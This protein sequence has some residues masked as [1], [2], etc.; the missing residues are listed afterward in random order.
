M[1]F[2]VGCGEQTESALKVVVNNKT[3][4]ETSSQA[5]T[6]AYG[7][8]ID[9]DAV[10]VMSDSTEKA[11]DTSL[12]QVTGDSHIIGTKPNAGTYELVFK[13]GDFEI[14]VSVVVT[15]LELIVPTAVNSTF[16]YN[17]EAQSL[18][19]SGFDAT[20]MQVTG[21]SYTD[22]D[23]YTAVISL[24]DKVNYTWSDGTTT[25]KSIAWTIAKA[26]VNV[27]TLA[28][29]V[30]YTYNGELQNVQLVGFETNLMHKV[31]GVSGIDADDYT[32]V[33]S[34]KDTDNYTWAD[35]TTANKNISWSIEKAR[36]NV[37]T[38]AQ[39]VEYT[40]NGELQEVEFTGYNSSIMNKVSGITG[41][42]ADDYTAVISLKDKT[43]YS[44]S[45]GT[46]TD[47]NISWSIEKAQVSVPTVA[48]NAT[49]T[50]N[51]ELQEV[52]FTGYNSSIMNK[53][54]GIT[55][56]DADDYTA[57]ISLKDTDNYTWTDGTT[58]NKNITWTINKKAVEVKLNRVLS[59]AYDGLNINNPRYSVTDDV[60]NSYKLY[61]LAGDEPVEVELL[62]IV[63]VGN[64]QLVVSTSD[65]SGN[66]E[67]INETFDF[68]IYYDI[69]LFTVELENSSFA[70]TGNELKPAVKV[71]MGVDGEENPIYL[72]DTY[73]EVIYRNNVMYYDDAYVL[74]QAKGA[75]VGEIIKSF[76]IFAE[77]VYDTISVNDKTIDANENKYDLT[78][79]LSQ[80]P[81][82]DL[83]VELILKDGYK[84]YTCDLIYYCYDEN[85]RC[86]VS[87]TD[88]TYEQ[89]LDGFTVPSDTRKL[90]FKF[91]NH[92]AELQMYSSGSCLYVYIEVVNTPEFIPNYNY[93]SDINVQSVR[94]DNERNTVMKE[95]LFT[96]DSL[97]S[98]IETAINDS[99]YN[100]SWN[101]NELGYTVSSVS[102]DNGYIVFTF[103]AE[104][105]ETLTCSYK[106]IEM[107]QDNGSYFN[108]SND[109]KTWYL[110]GA[111]NRLDLYLG[112]TSDIETELDAIFASQDNYWVD[113]NYA[114]GYAYSTY[115]I[116]ENKLEI[117]LTNG[118]PEQNIN[119]EYDIVDM[120]D[121]ASNFFGHIN[122]IFINSNSYIEFDMNSVQIILPVGFEGDILALV[123][124]HFADSSNYS[125][126]N[127][128]LS[129]Q[130]VSKTDNKITFAIKY[131]EY[132]D[133]Y[134][135][136]T[137]NYSVDFNIVQPKG[138]AAVEEIY[139][140]SADGDRKL[141]HFDDTKTL[142]ITETINSFDTIYFSFDNSGS[143]TNWVITDSDGQTVL[144]CTGSANY[145]RFNPIT[146]ADT[147]TL[148]M[149]SYS[150]EFE[151][152][153]VISNFDDTPGFKFTYNE[154]DYYFNMYGESDVYY[155]LDINE[156]LP[157]YIYTYLGE[158]QEG[159]ENITISVETLFP[160]A[161]DHENNPITDLTNIVLPI[162]T[163]DDGSKYCLMYSQ[164]AGKIL[165]VYFY[166]FD[167]PAVPANVDFELTF[168]KGALSFSSVPVV[169]EEVTYFGDFM[170]LDSETL[171][172]TISK[173]QID[174]I[175][176]DSTVLFEAEIYNQMGMI[177]Y[178]INYEST[179]LYGL[180]DCRGV[181]ESPVMVLGGETP[182]TCL[183][184]MATTIDNP[185]HIL[186][187]MIQII[188]DAPVVE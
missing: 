185:S 21:N 97:L 161:S 80:E 103:N 138:Y 79:K 96:G 16:T 156:Y 184:M 2:L 186:T 178:N 173:S 22:A 183:L 118:N 167:M 140:E 93:F 139:F 56:T 31:S 131:E 39:N 112:F 54:S 81:T 70:Y 6:V 43:N 172:A 48:Q 11:I 146:K 62:D 86:I 92:D 114:M 154:Q 105:Q 66:Y 68:S 1:F 4:T 77:D 143:L 25:D 83:E 90:E 71:I 64:Y 88:I 37:P 111:N 166:L 63:N 125:M 87:A 58:A 132:V 46:S 35:G 34:L 129:V 104:G 3:Y 5:C 47:K 18:V 128:F 133:E 124:Q 23:N 75:A 12:L 98:A 176:G 45:D 107:P 65:D 53:V 158:V 32:A 10:V 72:P 57:V 152:T 69:S 108:I 13:Y 50:Y 177:M 95:I 9:Y 159:T 187:L 181:F 153:I 85:N 170:A 51:G 91:V 101:L 162:L 135:T 115:A 73:Y 99:N 182:T 141:L 116:S 19:L 42:D 155:K 123:Q 122:N 20:L 150:D 126:Y 110:D 8:T 102:E 76:V 55:G 120:S 38:L 60:V 168:A 59:K 175:D 145:V 67:N 44:W 109:N 171:V 127:E 15:P 164:F 180:A 49:Y 14:E 113:T 74:V 169:K 137:A 26:Q 94:F 151:Y 7:T 52:E 17:T 179:V 28:Q 149:Q 82:S 144:S 174:Y 36:V 134:N 41:T 163:D 40:Y 33:I 130:S 61:S 119:L 147:Y 165:P 24:K 160:N 89:L 121:N 136:I 84:N 117:T 78:I 29:N 157:E 148:T 30:E 188:D 27:P 142:T 106:I 100:L